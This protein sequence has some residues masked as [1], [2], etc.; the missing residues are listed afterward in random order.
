[1]AFGNF[2][3]FF[4]GRLQVEEKKWWVSN[5]NMALCGVQCLPSTLERLK[6]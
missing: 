5:L 2:G 1:M 4:V 6:I 3:G